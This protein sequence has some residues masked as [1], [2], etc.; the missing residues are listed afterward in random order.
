MNATGRWTESGALLA[1]AV[2]GV[3]LGVQALMAL[4]PHLVR[5]VVGVLLVAYGT[6]KLMRTG[7]DNIDSD[8]CAVPDDS[9]SDGAEKQNLPLA[10]TVLFGLSAGILGGAVAEPGPPA[11]VFGTLRKW[12]PSEQRTMLSRF[13]LP[14]QVLA[15]SNF[16]AAGLFTSDLLAQS[17]A[18]IPGVVMASLAGTWIN[19]RIDPGRFAGAVTTIVIALGAISIS[20][21]VGGEL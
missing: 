5:G 7:C 4:D 11:V 12:T 3:P 19:R 18:A 13:F 14:V 17:V 15:M 21:A 8:F 2:L 1:S 9:V 20:A 10:K 6:W 16:A